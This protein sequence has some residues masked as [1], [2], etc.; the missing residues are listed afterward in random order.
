MVGWI[1]RG[2][3]VD[4]RHE[5]LRR[6]FVIGRSTPVSSSYPGPGACHRTADRAKHES[7]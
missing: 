5:C 3:A 6:A 2:S 1:A 4:C 7:G